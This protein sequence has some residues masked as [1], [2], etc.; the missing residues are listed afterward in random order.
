V[1]SG[2][3]V[4]EE[5]LE[6]ALATDR[7]GA[8][9]V[10][11]A[12]FSPGFATWD[13]ADSSLP[14]IHLTLT[15]MFVRD[16]VQWSMP[17]DAIHISC[18]LPLVPLQRWAA[19][20]RVATPSEHR[21]SLAQYRTTGGGTGWKFFWTRE[22]TSMEDTEFTLGPESPPPHA[23]LNALLE[24]VTESGD[25]ALPLRL[26]RAMRRGWRPVLAIG[27]QGSGIQFHAHA[28]TWFALTHGVKAWWIGPVRAARE[29][30]QQGNNATA[31]STCAYLDRRPHPELRL[32]IQKPGDVLFFGEWVPHATCNLE[33]TIG[34]GYQMGFYKTAHANFLQQP[35]RTWMGASLCAGS[36]G[37]RAE[38]AQAWVEEMQRHVSL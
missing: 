16:T 37:T 21:L 32:V 23:M 26:R 25:A 27:A 24:A 30:V 3:N 18:G 7:D 4:T 34:V 29:L 5:A 14:Q 6:A 28:P 15:S 38:A 1:L 36:N 2:A 13:W 35:S 33:D 8:A 19:P 11:G 9:L 12:F 20:R 10:R 17:T 22:R 31:S